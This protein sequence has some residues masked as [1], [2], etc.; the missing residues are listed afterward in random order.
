MGGLKILKKEIPEIKF[1][2]CAEDP[3]ISENHAKVMSHMCTQM[4]L[5]VDGVNNYNEHTDQTL[6]R[7]MKKV[8]AL[9]DDIH[10]WHEDAAVLARDVVHLTDDVNRIGKKLRVLEARDHTEHTEEAKDR[11]KEDSANKRAYLTPVIE[12]VVGVFVFLVRLG[13]VEFIKENARIENQALVKQ[14]VQA[15]LKNSKPTN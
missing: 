10:Q 15:E 5:I 3:G 12:V 2:S 13:A 6:D 9:R 4:E 7:I 1:G 11:R 8:D 14:L